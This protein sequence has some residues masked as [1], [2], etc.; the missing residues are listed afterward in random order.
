MHARA[1][2]LRIVSVDKIL[3]FTNTLIIN[4]L[5]NPNFKRTTNIYFLKTS[6][7]LLWLVHS[8]ST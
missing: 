7:F 8:A 3:R 6:E 4:H 5:I 2:M 1:R